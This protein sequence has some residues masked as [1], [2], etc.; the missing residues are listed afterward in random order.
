MPNV[1][2]ARHGHAGASRFGRCDNPVYAP[3]Q[4]PCRDLAVVPRGYAWLRQCFLPWARASPLGVGTLSP[5]NTFNA[6]RPGRPPVGSVAL[7][8]LS[9]PFGRLF[10]VVPPRWGRPPPRRAPLALGQALHGEAGRASARP[11]GR[12]WLAFGLRVVAARAALHQRP[13]LPRSAP[14]FGPCKLRASSAAARLLS[15][16]GGQVFPPPLVAGLFSSVV[17]LGAWASL[18]F[19]R[20]PAR[21]SCPRVPGSAPRP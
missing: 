11:P 6:A 4:L 7:V 2:T 21:P 13:C 10:A 20:F 16:G 9:A 5:L 18:R 17:G 8:P 12:L 15:L 14:A 1:R 19:A 3:N